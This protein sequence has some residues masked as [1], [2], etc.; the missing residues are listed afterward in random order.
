MKTLV[1]RLQ[2]TDRLTDTEKELA[3]FILEHQK[4]ITA[5]SVKELSERAF[6]S[7]A[8]ISRLCRK[9]GEDGYRNFQI[10]LAKELEIKS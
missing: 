3:G 10:S 1:E 9:L 2:E 7:K 6:V 4:E 8:S 5:L